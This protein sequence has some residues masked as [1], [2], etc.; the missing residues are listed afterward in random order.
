MNPADIAAQLRC[1]SGSDARETA[2][3]M[4]AAN[5]E[6]NRRVISQ[7]GITDNNRVL[8]IGP[9]NAAFAPEIIGAA[10]QVSYCG[11]DH[12]ADMV[13][14]ARER[15][16]DWDHELRFEQGSSDAIPWPD[17]YFD[18]VLAVHTLYFWKQPLDHLREIHRVMKPGARFALAFGDISF[19]RELPF[20]LY[21]FTLYDQQATTTLLKE[22][23]FEVLQAVS[24]KETGQSNT[25]E[26]VEK[27]INI[28]LCTL[29]NE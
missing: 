23:G 19:M 9:A 4:N 22:A 3:R 20:T 28:L 2:E 27:Q 17:A 15:Y 8:E 16:R 21:G 29:V 11:L 5:G 26:N 24:H 12:S 14:Q 13:Q 6:T 25:G 10:D 7:L 1:P 18:R